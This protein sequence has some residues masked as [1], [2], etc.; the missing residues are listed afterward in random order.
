ML[1]EFKCGWVMVR[2]TS[3]T[4]NSLR[5]IAI[6]ADGQKVGQLKN[7][8]SRAFELSPGEHQIFAKIDWCKTPLL[9]VS[10]KAGE[11][12]DLIVGSEMT[13]WRIFLAAFYLLFSSKL[14]YL[15]FV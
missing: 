3:Q 1:D 15:K 10:V 13:G 2:R 7:G 6:F 5:S 12:I 4:A 14:I 8:E 9:A 11:T